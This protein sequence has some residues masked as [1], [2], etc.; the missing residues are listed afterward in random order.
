MQGAEV[1]LAGSPGESKEN[2]TYFPEERPPGALDQVWDCSMAK[3]GAMEDCEEQQGDGKDYWECSP[4]VAFP[5]DSG[6]VLDYSTAI[7]GGL[8]NFVVFRVVDRDFLAEILGDLL[9]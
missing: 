4:E 7:E 2:S 9:R 6:Q 5:S 8:A 1:G 3:P